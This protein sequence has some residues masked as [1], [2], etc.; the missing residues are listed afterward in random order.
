MYVKFAFY[1]YLQETN[2]TVKYHRFRI[3]PI[4]NYWNPWVQKMFEKKESSLTQ[5]KTRALSF[6][7][8]NAAETS[9]YQIV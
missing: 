5:F 1:T 2:K 9:N 7:S 4:T 6:K 8:H 3:A